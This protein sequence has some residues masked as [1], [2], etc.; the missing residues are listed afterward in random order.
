MADWGS[1]AYWVWSFPDKTDILNEL[2]DREMFTINAVVFVFR[3]KECLNITR[4]LAFTFYS[5]YFPMSISYE[6]YI[7]RIKLF[8]PLSYNQQTVTI[9]CQLDVFLRVDTKQNRCQDLISLIYW[10]QRIVGDS[11]DSTSRINR[12]PETGV[13]CPLDK[14]L[15]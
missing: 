14:V 13:S 7:R 12:I 2:I 4:P 10:L 11:R 15:A 8:V 5:K 3:Q 1:V 9:T 6:Q